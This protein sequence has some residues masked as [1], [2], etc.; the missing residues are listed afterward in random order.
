MSVDK[1]SHTPDEGEV[2]YDVFDETI[3]E[4]F[5]ILLSDLNT[6]PVSQSRPLGGK[7]RRRPS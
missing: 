2:L 4:R 7:A 5:S 6:P 1:S 3:H